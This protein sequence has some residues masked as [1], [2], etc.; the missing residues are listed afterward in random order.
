ML[1]NWNDVHRRENDL[2]KAWGFTRRANVKINKPDIDAE[3]SQ[4]HNVEWEKAS[5]RRTKPQRHRLKNWTLNTSKEGQCMQVGIRSRTPVTFSFFSW[6]VGACLFVMVLFILF[7]IPENG[8]IRQKKKLNWSMTATVM[9]L[10]GGRKDATASSLSHIHSRV[11]WTW[12][13]FLYSVSD[14]AK[15]EK[16]FS[17]GQ[18]SIFRVTRLLW[19]SLLYV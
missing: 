4:K 7:H 11:K 5:S 13:Y 10:G 12:C 8:L 17:G 6:V 9:G 16:W 18:N 14:I 3:S 15:I 2:N 1:G 19:T